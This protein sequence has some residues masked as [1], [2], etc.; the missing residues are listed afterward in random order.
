METAA[1]AA[2]PG[3]IVTMVVDAAPVVSGANSV[4]AADVCQGEDTKAAFAP[5][6][7]EVDLMCCCSVAVC[8]SVI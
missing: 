7:F 1:E 4:A 8:C 3:D 5:S 6:W 2:N